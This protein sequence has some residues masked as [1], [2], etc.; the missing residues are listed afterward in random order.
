MTE[1]PEDIRKAREIVRTWGMAN[2]CRHPVA[3]AIMAERVS[4]T[5]A[6]RERLT[7]KVTQML[8]DLHG[9]RVIR[10]DID[11]IAAAIREGTPPVGD[12]GEKP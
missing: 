1:I 3:A 9:Q 6:E 12:I 5:A 7:A 8:N 11:R 4:A 10:Y 2:H